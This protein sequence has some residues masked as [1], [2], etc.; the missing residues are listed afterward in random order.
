MNELDDLAREIYWA[1][2]DQYLDD[3]HHHP[4][5][6]DKE[7]AWEGTSETQKV[8]CR[9]QARRALAWVEERWSLIS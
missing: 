1:A 7:A 2:Y 9:N 6:L 3:D 4:L 8:F 5:W